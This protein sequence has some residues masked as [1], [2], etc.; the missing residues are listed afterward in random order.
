MLVTAARAQSPVAALWHDPG[1]VTA[2]DF[3]AAAGSNVQPPKPP[4][5]FV[6]EDLSGTQ[7]KLFVKDASGGTWNVKFGY[8]VKNES[9]CWRLVRA[10]GYFAEPSF[11]VAEG[12][13]QGMPT[14][15]RRADSIQP[16]GKFTAARFQFRDPSLK[17]EKRANWRW[18]R[19]PL[20]GT[21]ELD[22]LKVLIMLFSNWD[23]KDA[24]VGKGG[25]NTAVF[26]QGTRRIYAFTDWGSGMGRWG[27]DT[28]QTDWRCEDYTAQTAEF[29]KGARNGFVTFGWEGDINGGFRDR[30]PASH[31][32]WLYQYLGRITDVQLH[33]GLKA[34][35]AADAEAD[36]FTKALR[37]RIEQLRVVAAAQ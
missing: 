24:R 19:A 28:G 27:S 17:F 1:D 3:G 32:A 33:A 13:V 21:R 25:P 11:F 6:R 12:Q 8:E 20:A 22:G 2:L 36:C 9:F 31:V 15:K 18:D 16:D 23:N 4:F 14:L 5:T 35:G 30:I 37:A 26:Q 29:V 34:A 7:P 10:C